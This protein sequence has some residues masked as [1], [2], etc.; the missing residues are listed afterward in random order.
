MPPR[1]INTLQVQN[2][3]SQIRVA[4]NCL[5]ITLVT[6]ANQ[7]PQVCSGLWSRVNVSWIAALQCSHDV[8]AQN[9]MQSIQLTL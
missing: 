7:L 4:K 5:Q 9:M 1:Q 2:L 3:G 8:K 6:N